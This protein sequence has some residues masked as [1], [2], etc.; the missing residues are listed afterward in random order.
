YFERL[1]DEV[2][3]PIV[4]VSHAAAEVARLA[5]TVVALEKGWVIRQGPAIEVLGDP[6]IA[7]TGIRAV[8]A[9][10]EAKVA[11]HHEDGLT[12]LA[13]GPEPLF[14]PR[15]NQPVGKTLRIRI[16]AQEV[17]LARAY[18]QDLSALNILSGTV[19]AVRTGEGPG[20]IVS[21]KTAAGAVLARV[22]Q[23]SVARLGLAP[24]SECFAVLK[25]V[26]VAPED[27]GQG[28]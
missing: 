9:L 22:T 13:A 2:S 5:T 26:A 6:M 4:Y 1:R 18:P 28:V 12:E 11:A 3:I 16:A 23:R 14:L 15:I 7:P 8:G 25:S 27:V 20:A 19:E 10:L 24:G 17:I 21:V